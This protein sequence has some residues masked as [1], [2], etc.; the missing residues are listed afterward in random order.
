MEKL[1]SGLISK[2]CGLLFFLKRSKK[3][4]EMV[5]D[6]IGNT[7]LRT[8]LNGLSDESNYYAG[9]LKNYLSSLGAASSFTEGYT[10][11]P[12]VFEFYPAG[13]PGAQG[14]ELMNICTHNELTLVQAYNELLEE[15]M[16][17]QNLKDIMLYQL[18][19]LKYTFMKI[20]ILNSAR[21]AVY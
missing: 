21:F 16:P 7:S 20:K 2:F 5:A 8:A 9:E 1:S 4:F 11:D 15:S 14:D 6:E 18:N 10:E 3:E 13:E 17:F 19:A 12:E